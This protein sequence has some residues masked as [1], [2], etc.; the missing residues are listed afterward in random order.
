MTFHLEVRAVDVRAYLGP[1]KAGA[2]RLTHA[3]V[4]NSDG[5]VVRVIC[6]RV[7]AESIARRDA[8]IPQTVDALLCRPCRQ[9]TRGMTFRPKAE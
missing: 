6:R 8:T 4:V 1:N 2:R 3:V 9:K 7:M 5:G